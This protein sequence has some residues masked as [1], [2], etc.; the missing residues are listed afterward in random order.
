MTGRGR[1]LADLMERRKVAW[2]CVQEM[3]W[4]G[5]K[6][7]NIGAGC[8]LIYS[9]ANAQG[10][11]GV[12][13]VLNIL[14]CG[15][16]G[17]KRGKQRE[18]PKI[19]WWKLEEEQLKDQFKERVMNEITPKE[20]ANEWWR[21]NSNII[22]R[23][24]E[25]LLGK[26]S[27][28]GAP[29]DKEWWWWNE[30]VQ[31]K[32]KKKKEAKKKWDSSGSEED[33]EAART[34]KKEAKKAVAQAKVNA[35]NDIYEELET[36]VGVKKIYKLAKRRNKANK[37][38]AQIK[39]IKDEEGCVLSDET[40]IKNRWRV[41]FE[42]LLNEENERRVFGEGA[43][44]EMDAPEISKEEV[45]RALRRINRGKATGPVEMP[46]EVW[47]CLGDDGVE[48]LWDLLRKVYEQEKIPDEWRDSV[49]IPIYKE[50][51]DIQDCGNYRERIRGTTK[52][53][54]ILKKVQE[55]R[56]QWIRFRHFPGEQMMKDRL[57][58]REH[59]GG[60][61]VHTWAAIHHGEK[62]ALYILQG[63][64]NDA[65]YRHH[66]ETI[67]LQ[68]ASA[69]FGNNCVFQNGKATAHSARIV[70][71]YLDQ[72]NVTRLLWPVKSP[73]CNPVENCWTELSPNIANHDTKPATV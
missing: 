33:E 39:Q 6:S 8:K 59:T 66:V 50:K 46:A 49:I 67:F 70:Q 23:I 24:G 51:G 43:A 5:N 34:A 4:S 47:K 21:E 52:V 58:H 1:E 56:L 3:K 63:N 16:K 61:A 20:N 7:R 62:T 37:D 15:V 60:D 12:G 32:V 30:E 40:E 19:K 69:R 42:K 13:I 35:V 73:D 14:D 2:L 26:T 17:A 55:R 9:G 45:K 72:E 31:E 29:Q 18:V 41:Y 28:R 22:R 27:G 54:E 48:V 68:Y 64:V 57:S 11:N 65:S 44:N 38:L 53:V 25:E 71:D 10:R 36:P